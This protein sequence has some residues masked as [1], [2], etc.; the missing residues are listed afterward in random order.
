MS[1]KSVLVACLLAS[2]ALLGCASTPAPAPTCTV[3]CAPRAPKRM[4]RPVAALHVPTTP[5]TVIE[6]PRTKEGGVGLTGP[7]RP[8]VERRDNSGWSGRSTPPDAMGGGP[9]AE[10]P[11]PAEE[12]PPVE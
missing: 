1:P 11:A 3:A 9:P 7:E 12:P 8:Y 10:A 6:V 2:G 4:I 5:L